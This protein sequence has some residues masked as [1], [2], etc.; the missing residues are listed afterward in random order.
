MRQRGHDQL[1][2]GAGTQYED[3]L[4]HAETF[5]GLCAG[6]V[7]AGIGIGGS[8][9]AWSLWVTKLAPEG[10]ETEYMSAHVAFTGVRGATAPFLG[11]AVLDA[12]GFR[13][14]GWTS[15]ALIAASMLIFASA[16]RHPRFR[17]S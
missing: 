15:A 9:I 2:D 5:A 12:V 7:L 13:G 8:T 17:T 4:V 6:A 11:Y 10:R 14:V 3:R 1:T 16:A